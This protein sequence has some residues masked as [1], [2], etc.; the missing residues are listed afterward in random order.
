MALCVRLVSVAHQHSHA[1]SAKGTAR[2]CR[3]TRLRS[4]LSRP[5]EKKGCATF[6]N[7]LSRNGTRVGLS[8]GHVAWRSIGVRKGLLG[9]ARRVGMR[10]GAAARACALAGT[11]RPSAK[12]PGPVA[13]FS[14]TEL[15]LRPMATAN[16]ID[17]S[18]KTNFQRVA[19]MQ[20]RVQPW[21]P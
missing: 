12:R 17:D 10:K 14:L 16:P 9:V 2:S 3:H 20:C 21:S 7:Q 11:A 8:E 6:K 15:V 5:A 19:I 13:G 1:D 18:W 4:Q